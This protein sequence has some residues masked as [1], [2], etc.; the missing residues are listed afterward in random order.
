MRR[1]IKNN[2]SLSDK[3][4]DAII[5]IITTQTFSDNKLPAESKLAEHFGVSLPVVREALLLLRQEGV[6]TKK[7]GSGNYFHLSALRP[8]VRI[9]KFRGFLSWISAMGY[10]PS[11]TIVKLTVEPAHPKAQEGL[12]LGPEEPILHYERQLF[13][14]G[15]P[16]VYCDNYLPLKYFR[17]PYTD[18]FQKP[19]SI[20][21]I[22]NECYGKDRA[23]GNTEFIPH[24]TTQ[25]EEEQICIPP[26]QP[27]I[28]LAETYYSLEDIP[29][30][31]S[32]NKFNHDILSINMLNR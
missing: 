28:I 13:A 26:G 5:T 32:L 24:L 14:D 4:R 11:D 23:Y 12:G 27:I 22:I 2:Q 29:V 10:E 19:M 18:C 15:V 1:L 17:Q 9:N 16:A 31:Y 25:K 20:V 21:E 7:H 3:V 8:D 30:V 6:V